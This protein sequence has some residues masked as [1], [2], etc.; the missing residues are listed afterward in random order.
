[1]TGH[2]R[3]PLDPSTSA[4]P[5]NSSDSVISL[6]STEATVTTGGG[7][8]R[9]FAAVRPEPLDKAE[10]TLAATARTLRRKIRFRDIYLISL[11]SLIL[12]PSMAQATFAK[13]VVSSPTSESKETA[14]RASA[15]SARSGRNKCGNGVC[16]AV[17]STSSIAFRIRDPWPGKRRSYRACSRFSIHPARPPTSCKRRR[18]YPAQHNWVSSMACSL[19][20]SRIIWRAK[21]LKPA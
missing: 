5:V 18:A 19:E 8:C 1:M 17:T 3:T 10:S 9:G 2:A 14:S 16:R 21:N 7:G 4:R 12:G 6:C 20:S 13:E 15:S 11:I